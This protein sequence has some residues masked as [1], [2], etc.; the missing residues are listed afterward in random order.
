V[1]GTHVKQ[2]KKSITMRDV[3]KGTFEEKKRK[4]G[5]GRR[6]LTVMP[7]GPNERKAKME[8]YNREIFHSGGGKQPR[9]FR[10]RKRGG[11]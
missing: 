7:R 4:R 9:I 2:R 10:G 6:V 5:K 1:D 8:K 3:G 11:K